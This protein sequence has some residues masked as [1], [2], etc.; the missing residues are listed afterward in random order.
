[1]SACYVDVMA[2]PFVAVQA[3]HRFDFRRFVL[4]P[5]LPY[6]VAKRLM[7]ESNCFLPARRYASAVLAVV[8][9]PSVCP[10]VRPSIRLS[11][12]GTV[13]TRL[14]AGSHK[15]HCASLCDSSGT[16][17]FCCQRSRRNS[18]GINESAN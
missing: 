5:F 3:C 14:N 17:V 15:Q 12:A 9:C 11:Q 13:P 10:S 7:N 4:S 6:S 1:M 8:V 18:N 2:M 16:L